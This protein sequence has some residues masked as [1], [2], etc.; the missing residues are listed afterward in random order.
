MRWRSKCG[1][2][3]RTRTRAAQRSWW[4]AAQ[5]RPLQIFT[6]HY[7]CWGAAFARG[8]ASPVQSPQNTRIG[9][10]TYFDF[11]QEHGEYLGPLCSRRASQRD[12]LIAACAVG[13]EPGSMGWSVLRGRRR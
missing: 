8:Q 10:F 2:R 11:R 13:S 1:L 3:S 6:D 4:S 7:V 9:S 5:T 12:Q